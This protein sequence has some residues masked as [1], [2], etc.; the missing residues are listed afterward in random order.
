MGKKIII[1]IS[2]D[3]DLLTKLPAA[4]IRSQYIEGAIRSSLNRSVM[5]FGSS[6]VRVKN[7]ARILDMIDEH[8]Y[9]SKMHLQ[10]L[11]TLELGI[12]EKRFKEYVESLSYN[13]KIIDN[14]GWLVSKSYVG[15]MPWTEEGIRMR[16]EKNREKSNNANSE[17]KK[18]AEEEADEILG[19]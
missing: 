18:Q 15:P 2:I 19:G 13:E 10:K 17:M 5:N 6:N 1:S 16:A 14:S 9:V 4:P 7:V 3:E 12:T 11:I 8:R